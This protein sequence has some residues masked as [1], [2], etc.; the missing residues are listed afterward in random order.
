MNREDFNNDKV[1]AGDINSGHTVTALYEIT[2]VG[3]DAALLDPLRYV[4]E[5]AAPAANSGEYAFIKLRYKQP[6][7]SFS[8]LIERPATDADFIQNV[9]AAP[10][11]VRFGV[12]VTGF[13]Q[14]LRD[15]AYIGDYSFDQV[16][17]LAKGA[18]GQDPFGYRNEFTSLVR[19]ARDIE[20]TE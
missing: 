1:D 3:S 6:G 9:D 15:S 13:G 17:A 19:L 2:P 20:R 7:Q 10:E 12:A 16:E 4:Q 11:E 8:T 5:Q 14:I 18:L